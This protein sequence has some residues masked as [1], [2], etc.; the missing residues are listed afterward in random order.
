MQGSGFT[1]NTFQSVGVHSAVFQATDAHANTAACTLTAT[2]VDAE[3][4]TITCPA[5]VTVNNNAT[6]CY[7]AVWFGEPIVNDNCDP[8]QLTTVISF[9]QA[10]GSVF[11]VGVVSEAFRTTDAAGLSATCTFNITVVDAEPPTI[12]MLCYVR[13]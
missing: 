8:S 4:P 10:N 9:G 2:V 7:S 1:N 3:A 6:Y 5:A 13:G 11:A 12:S